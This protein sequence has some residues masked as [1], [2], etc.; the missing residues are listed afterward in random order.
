MQAQKGFCDVDPKSLE[1]AVEQE[2]SGQGAEA[3]ATSDPAVQFYTS[4]LDCAQKTIAE[5]GVLALYR[6]LGPQLLGVAPEKAVK[7]SVN[8]IM[9]AVLMS[10]LA[11]QEGEQLPFW[12]SVVAGACAGACQVIV[13]NPLEIIKIRLQMQTAVTGVA[14]RSATQLIADIGPRGL[15]K[16]AAAC[17]IRDA[18]FSGVFFSLYNVLKDA[19]PDGTVYLLLAGTLAAAPAAFI[20]TPADCLKTRMQVEGAEKVGMWETFNSIIEEEGPEALF[21]GASQRVFRSGPQFGIT[22]A[23]FDTLNGFISGN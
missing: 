4:T 2:E 23:V 3:T 5:G 11:L 13:T 9:R 7:L 10:T 15:Y 18:P 17:V 6:G 19:F 16:G 22:L 1:C 14:K 21:K 12:A 20:V 8:D